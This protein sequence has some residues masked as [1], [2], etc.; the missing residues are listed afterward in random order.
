MK[1]FT[2]SPP[3]RCP[4]MRTALTALPAACLALLALAPARAA[5]DAKDDLAAQVREAIRRGVEF[6]KDQEGGRGQWEVDLGGAG[7]RG[8]RTCLAM[9]ALLNA[10]VP[11]DDPVIKR[12]LDYLREL[13]PE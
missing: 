6:L 11:P 4:P 9:L 1:G 12:G 2:S 3:R 10:G 5:E 13:P 7:Y 8:G